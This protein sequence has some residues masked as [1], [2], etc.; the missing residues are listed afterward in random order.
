MIKSRAKARE[1]T[2]EEYMKGNLLLEEVKA[3]DVAK[4][5]FHL[6]ISKK[7]RGILLFSRELYSKYS[8]LSIS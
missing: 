2:S 1:V 5:F 7:T 4:A 8:L 3:E 6:A